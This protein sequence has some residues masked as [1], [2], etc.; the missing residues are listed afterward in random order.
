[1][2]INGNAVQDENGKY[3]IVVPHAACAGYPL[4]YVSVR[5]GEKEARYSGKLTDILGTPENVLVEVLRAWKD[6]QSVGDVG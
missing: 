2:L 4:G 1:M 6:L 3:W 5:R